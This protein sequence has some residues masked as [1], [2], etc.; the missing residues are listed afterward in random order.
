MGTWGCCQHHNSNACR[1][2]TCP[3]TWQAPPWTHANS[4]W[5]ESEKPVHQR[6]VLSMRHQN[7]QLFTLVP[8]GAESCFDWNQLLWRCVAHCL[9]LTPR[10][11]KITGPGVSLSAATALS[12]RVASVGVLERNAS[13]R[14]ERWRENAL[15]LQPK[16]RE[17]ELPRA[18]C[19]AESLAPEKC[20]REASLSVTT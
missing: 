18:R 4:G 13:W 15:C 12:V 10:G 16:G 11:G 5:L 8:Q 19:S 3:H 17:P 20:L 1:A 9:H 2:P 7:N 14:R 6:A